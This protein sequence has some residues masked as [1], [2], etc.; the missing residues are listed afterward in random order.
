MPTLPPCWFGENLSDGGRD[1]R[2]LFPL[3]FTRWTSKRP[4]LDHQKTSG[5]PVCE[6]EEGRNR[7][8]SR[9]GERMTVRSE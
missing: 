9:G 2:H 7:V 6:A 4:P 8:S 5:M 3:R 1:S